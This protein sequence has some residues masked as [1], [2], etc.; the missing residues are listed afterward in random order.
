MKKVVVTLFSLLLVCQVLLH[1]TALPEAL[2]PHSTTHALLQTGE[3]G[4]ASEKVQLRD[5]SR[6]IDDI[7]IPGQTLPRQFEAKLWY[8]KSLPDRPMP[9]ILYSHGLMGSYSQS[10]H[11][12]EH[13]ASHGYLFAAPDFP[14]TNFRNGER[15]NAV[16]VINQPGDIS[17]LLDA[18]LRR[19]SDPDDSLYQRIDSDKIVA[20]GLSL[21]GMTTHMLAYDPQRADAR[22]DV[23]VAIAAPSQMFSKKFF[24]TRDL[25]YLAIASP[26]DALIAYRDNALPMLSKARNASLVTIAGGS[27]V[28]YTHSARWLRWM[29]NPDAMACDPIK[30][31]L[32]NTE[33][34]QDEWFS[35]LGSIEE[36]YIVESGGDVCHGE[37]PT[38]MNPIR[39]SD[40]AIAASWSFLQCQFS[41]QS[42]TVCDDFRYR[43]AEENAAVSVQS[44]VIQPR[45]SS[46]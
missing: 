20:M 3:L 12:A 30:E 46:R 38:T 11:Y 42:A 34:A 26:E 21:G 6:R 23:A 16:D 27:H 32:Q 13:F 36:G 41:D 28:G 45:W 24:S 18:L 40:F 43:L 39:Q 17:F 35:L 9:L 29:D 14:L 1:F 10:A 19:N 44:N 5:P 31:N 8:P 37:L 15:A 2:P 22:I 7:D 25:P 33:A 4:V